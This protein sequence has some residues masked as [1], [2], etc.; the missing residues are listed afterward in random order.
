MTNTDVTIGHVNIHSLPKKLDSIIDLI[1]HH[2]ISVLGITET[3]LNHERHSDELVTLPEFTCERRDSTHKLHKGVIVYIHCAIGHCVKRRLDLEVTNV[4]CVWIEI[5]QFSQRPVLVGFLYRNPRHKIDYDQSWCDDFL[6]MMTKVSS[7]RLNL[8]LLGDFNI[9]LLKVQEEWIAN[10]TA[11]GLTQLIKTPTRVEKRG[12]LITQS[13]IDHIYTNSPDLIHNIFA[14]DIGVSDHKPIICTWSCKLP[15]NGLKCHKYMWYHSSNKFDEDDFCADLCLANLD[16]LVL[17][18]STA[19][20]AASAW[21]A[22]FLAIVDKHFPLR[23]Q[24]IKNQPAPNWLTPE[25]KEAMRMRDKLKKN[26]RFEEYKK[27]RNKVTDLLRKSK[28]EYYERTVKD[29]KNMSQVWQAVNVL[30]N[31]KQLRT[32]KSPLQ[33]TPDEANSYFVSVADTIHGTSAQTLPCCLDDTIKSNIKDFC[34]SKLNN[35]DSFTI[36]FLSVHDVVRLI[37]K[38]NNKKT[39][40]P[41]TLNAKIIKYALPCISVSLTILYNRCLEEQTFPSVFKEALVIPLPKGKKPSSLDDFRPISILPILSKPLEKHLHNHLLS[42]MESKHL[43]H[44]YQSGFRPNHSCHTALIRMC[45]SWL[46]NIN[47]HEITGTLFL[48]LRKAFN[49]VNHEILLEKLTLYLQ[50]N[51]VVHFFASYLSNRSQKTII[52]GSLSSA[53][54]LKCGVPQG[55]ILGPLLFSIYINDLPLFLRHKA[56]VPVDLFA[57]DCTL[58]ARGKAIT[59][60]QQVLQDS[61]NDVS[62]WCSSNAM[63]LNHSKSKSMVISTRQKHQLQ[64]L[65]LK[66]NIGLDTIEQVKVHRVLGCLIDE[67]MSFHPHIDSILKTM[68]R[69]IYLMSR[70]WHFVSTEALL[71]FFYGHCMSHINYASTIWCN[72]D[73][74][75]INKL[76]RLHKRAVKILFR[77]PNMTTI[78]KYK[79][80]KVLALKD[81]FRYNACKMVFRQSHQ[82]VPMYLQKLLPHKNPRTL[83]YTKPTGTS[84]L[85]ITQAGFTFS[86]VSAWNDLPHQCKSCNTLGTFKKAVH[87]HYLNQLSL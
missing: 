56:E 61:I 54:Y 72:T 41:D 77:A 48:D 5:R 64:P 57:D 80:L 82:L 75:Y 76:N 28:R 74:N 65:Q 33:F 50:N 84:R 25:I 29:S 36:P 44:E 9:D 58:S 11:L 17:N 46:E 8:I 12:P 21:S 69:N 40:G 62:N 2:S 68:S 7:C 73:E 35:S 71:A 26:K 14:S 49:C 13:L 19:D 34:S 27:Q 4:E 66:L 52:N 32:S 59:S 3:G 81:Q 20:N 31:K 70:L 43:F 51:N 23:K 53:G 83:V 6:H 39:M 24:R 47:D 10:T 37:S 87:K 30:S 55:S 45:N 15:P 78:E 18:S 16:H 67:T 60:I 85:N 79:H 86:G 1:S 42:Y 38:I 22:A 63:M